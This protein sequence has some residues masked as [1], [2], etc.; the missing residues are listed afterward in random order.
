MR[1]SRGGG[2]QLA[3]SLWSSSSSSYAAFGPH[4]WTDHDYDD[5]EDEPVGSLKGALVQR[6]MWSGPN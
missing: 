1:M 5:D 4:G 2:I 6:V 3:T